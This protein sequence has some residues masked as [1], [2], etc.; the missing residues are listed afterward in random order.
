[1]VLECLTQLAT[2]APNIDIDAKRH[3]EVLAHRMVP[4]ELGY[5][6]DAGTVKNRASAYVGA[7]REDRCSDITRSYP[8]LIVGMPSGE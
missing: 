2:D 1:M 5:S 7:E 6:I 8:R 3:P 4:S